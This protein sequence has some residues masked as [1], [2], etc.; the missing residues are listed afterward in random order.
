MAKPKGGTLSRLFEVSEEERKQFF[1]RIQDRF[2]VVTEGTVPMV[3]TVPM[4]STTPA[5]LSVGTR[6]TDSLENIPP[7]VATVPEDREQATDGTV[8]KVRTVR[9]R[10]VQDGHT[11]WEQSIYESLWREATPAVGQEHRLIAIGYRHIAALTTLGLKTIQRN[12][13]S[14]ERKLTLEPIGRYDSDTKSPK[15]YKVYSY[16]AILERRKDAGLEWVSINRQG[17]ELTCDPSLATVPTVTTVPTVGTDTVPTVTTRHSPHGDYSFRT[18]KQVQAERTSSSSAVCQVQQVITPL[19]LELDD[20]GISQII[21]AS[22]EV[23]PTASP[24]EIA[25]FIGIAV[26]RNH[27]G[28]V[29][30]W[31]GFLKAAVPKYL[32]EG[33]TTLVA[34]REGKAREKAELRRQAQAVQEDPQ[35]TQQE[36]EWA[37]GVLADSS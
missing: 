18:I 33:S 10:T 3:T 14:L 19:S 6:G 26:Q 12:M 15:T 27:R 35:A 13:K 7:S 4:V 36:R 2:H 34:Y 30:T 20:D 5:V 28:G 25:H 24:E 22:W 21:T 37:A 1:Q 11:V 9:A 16:K 23:N 17:V 31:V 8:P 29:R 32:V